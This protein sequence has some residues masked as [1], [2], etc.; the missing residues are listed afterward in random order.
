MLSIQLLN[1]N[2]PWWIWS[3]RKLTCEIVT[4]EHFGKVPFDKS[5]FLSII[6][7]ALYIFIYFILSR[8]NNNLWNW[9]SSMMG[10][11]LGS[12][13]Y[14]ILITGRYLMYSELNHFHWNQNQ[15]STLSVLTSLRSY[16]LVLELNRPVD[17]LK[18]IYTNFLDILKIRYTV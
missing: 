11:G 8:C 14:Q 3:L 4:E 2:A 10:N 17:P 5:T 1:F 18:L 12:K 13:L 9:I 15:K 16:C 6:Q 7:F